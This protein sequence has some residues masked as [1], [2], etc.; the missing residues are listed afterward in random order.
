MIVCLTNEME[1]RKLPNYKKI[2]RFISRVS[3]SLGNI[4]WKK[5]ELSIQLDKNNM[6]MKL[7]QEREQELQDQ[8]TINKGS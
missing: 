6:K 4:L 3:G 8:E 2:K 5:F 7:F 1:S